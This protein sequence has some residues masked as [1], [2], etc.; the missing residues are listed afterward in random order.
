MECVV[1]NEKRASKSAKIKEA[2]IYL[3]ANCG[4]ITQMSELS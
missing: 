4:K 3:E 1:Q 2:E